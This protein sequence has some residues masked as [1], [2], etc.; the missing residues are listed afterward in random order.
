MLTSAIQDL[1]YLYLL[2]DVTTLRGGV[3]IWRGN[4]GVRSLCPLKLIKNVLRF[5]SS[6][7]S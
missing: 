7:F 5:S 3:N 4:L 1:K 2:G 6:L